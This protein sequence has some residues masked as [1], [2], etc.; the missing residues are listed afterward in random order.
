LYLD[1]DTIIKSDLLS[2]FFTDVSDKYAAVV[3]DIKPKLV[4]KPS[5]LTKL[6]IESHEAYFNSGVML[7]NLKKIREDNVIDKLFSYR[8]NGLNFFM[9]QDALNVVFSGKV[10]YLPL[11]YNFLTTLQ[12]IF[13]IEEVNMNYLEASYASY[14]DV[15][16]KAEVVHFASKNKPWSGHRND[17]TAYWMSEYVRSYT[18]NALPI[19]H[20]VQYSFSPSDLV[21]SLTSYPA[22][23]GTVHITI[24]SIL[25]QVFR[26]SLVVLWLAE[27][28][29]PNKERDLPDQLL[30]YVGQGLL[31]GWCHDIRSYKKL[32]PSLG[33]FSN[34]VVV[35]ADD[36]IIYNE[37]WLG[38]LVASYLQEPDAIHCCRAHHIAFDS[39][40][41]VLPYRRWKRDVKDRASSYKNFFTGCGGVLYPP[42]S[43]HSDVMNE[44]S[45]T[46][47]CPYG[48]DIWFWG[49]AVLN[50]TKIKI[51]DQKFDLSFVPDS[52]DTALWRDNDK[53]GRNDVMLK[54]FF[55]RYPRL[56]GRVAGG[57]VPDGHDALTS[58]AAN[59]LGV[60]VSFRYTPKKKEDPELI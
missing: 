27:E 10:N 25:N 2:L 17:F 26:P 32:I 7:L 55:D 39:D 59:E 47:L 51:V 6:S 14:D 48:D 38:N 52:Q 29:F 4:Y 8:R 36:D 11:K 23:I 30:R 60:E 41:E 33:L 45:F 20:P 21:V 1:G 42:R 16:T 19:L 18:E 58:Y 15:A 49:M 24:E 57:D 9:D 31:I 43:L 50:G 56:V 28:Q 40:G 34:K 37:H 3:E 44:S 54:A 53:G 12:E 5:I 46:E 22:R 35:T 13:S